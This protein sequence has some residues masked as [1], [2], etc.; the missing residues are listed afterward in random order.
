MKHSL[1][2][3]SFCLCGAFLQAQEQSSP[4]AYMV[5]NA[6]LDTQWNWDIVTTI[7]KYVKNTLYQN[8]FLLDKYPNYVFNFEGGIKYYWMKEYYPEKY[9][10]LKERIKEGRWHI[11]GS[12]WEAA[13]AV[14]PSPESAIRNILL[15]QTFYRK[16]FNAE[17][18][19][20]FLPDCFGFPW[21]LPTVAAHCGL[22]GFSSQKL[23]WRTNPFYGEDRLPFTIGLWKGIDGSQIMFAHGYDYTQKWKDEDLSDN[24]Q[25]KGLVKETPLN[26]VNLSLIHI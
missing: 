10:E 14:V 6:H 18:T 7:D 16:E 20:I 23:A 15:G 12:S 9:E 24:E 13:D 3:A 26:M 19:D 22:I 25:L 8:L 1:L 17:G 5:S 2:I 11:A 4:K 21:T